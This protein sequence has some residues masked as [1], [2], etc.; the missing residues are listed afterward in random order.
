MTVLDF[1]KTED[2]LVHID[3]LKKVALEKRLILLEKKQYSNDDFRI[4]AF[5]QINRILIYHSLCLKLYIDYV[6]TDVYLN[7]LFEASTDDSI[8]IKKDYLVRTRHALFLNIQIIIE[9]FDRKLCKLLG[10][11]PPNSFSKLIDT[12][13]EKMKLDKTNDQYEAQRLLSKIRNTIH[14]N[15]IHTMKSQTIQYRNQECV[16]TKDEAVICADYF[17]AWCIISD[18]IDFLHIVG[19]K[20]IQ[21]VK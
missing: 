14:N 19:V 8:E 5:E 2:A 17:N 13:F 9:N 20:N 6:S 4:S 3:S 11:A 1:I 15:G 10:I 18:I 16:F 7:N 21:H 12:L